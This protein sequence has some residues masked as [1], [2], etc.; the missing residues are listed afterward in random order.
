VGDREGRHTEASTGQF[1]F[2]HQ[3]LI[4][5]TCGLAAFAHRAPCGF[6]SRPVGDREGRHTE[7]STGQFAFAH[8]ELVDRTCG[9]AAFA[10]RAQC[11]FI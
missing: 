6:V 5:R 10:H 7:A 9:L 8:Q 1:A 4:D 11:G 2:A 3:E